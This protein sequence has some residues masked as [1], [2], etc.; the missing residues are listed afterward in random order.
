MQ[1]RKPCDNR[2]RDWNDTAASQ[3][4]PRM[5]GHHQKLEEARKDSTQS[6]M[7]PGLADTLSLHS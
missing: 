4:M 6:Q 1:G 7:E 2:G 5:D 3:G